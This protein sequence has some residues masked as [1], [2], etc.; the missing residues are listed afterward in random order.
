MYSTISL[1]T[2]LANRENYILLD[3]RSPSEY[4]HAHIP[5]AVSVPIFTDEQRASIGTTYKQKSRAL[6][7]QEG[8]DY[9]GP[10][11]TS[12]LK[13]INKLVIKYPNKT[14]AITCARGGMRSAALCWLCSFNGWPTVQIIGGYKAYRNWI[15]DKWNY[16]YNF[17]I[18]AGFTG[19]AK[20]EVLQTLQSRNYAAIDLEA[21]SNHKGSA[22]GHIGLSGQCSQ[23]HFENKLG[24]ALF[25]LIDK[26]IFLEDESQ[27]I[28]KHVIPND[29]WK[30][31]RNAPLLFLDIPFAQRLHHL[32][33]E[34]GVLDKLALEESIL[35][36][37]KNLGGLE[38]K[39]ALEAL[40]KNEF[41]ECF[42]I[43]LKYYDKYYLKAGQKRENY[44]KLKINIPSENTNPII[45]AEKI[46]DIINSQKL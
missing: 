10:N 24:E 7:I 6:A 22:F 4:A 34:Y 38:T 36:V 46:I 44:D 40:M 25:E 18:I 17:K 27:R 11:M 3:T 42:S 23:E 41:D 29:L 43:L 15:I 45:N 5:E 9:F 39:L 1:Q 16:N 20:T 19:S 12:L 2:Y 26:T 8:L 30:T 31:M 13:Q 21:L 35:R 32:V 28:G 14:I 33:K 37:K